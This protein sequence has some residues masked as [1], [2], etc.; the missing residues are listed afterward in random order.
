[1]RKGKKREKEN[2][3]VSY[4]FHV[5]TDIRRKF[6]LGAYNDSTP[7]SYALIW[8]VCKS[9][10]QFCVYYPL[11]YM[12]LLTSFISV[13]SKSLS[14]IIMNDI[15]NVIKF[16]LLRNWEYGSR[17]IKSFRSNELHRYEFH[18]SYTNHCHTRYRC[19]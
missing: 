16:L 7:R 18:N 8:Q 13:F 1:M 4:F 6:H 14:N 10:A 2:S 12:H 15:V 17:F 9:H 5:A 11:T 19:D 3:N